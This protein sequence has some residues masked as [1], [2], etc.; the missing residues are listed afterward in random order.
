MQL[1]LL[2]Q[3]KAEHAWALL[4]DPENRLWTEQADY[5]EGALVLVELSPLRQIQ[6]IQDATCW[7]LDIVKHYLGTGMTPTLLEEE[8]QRAEQWRQ[9]LTLKNQE[10][11]RRVLEIEARRDQ[12]QELEENLKIEK[13][14]LEQ[15]AAQFRANLNGK[16]DEPPTES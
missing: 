1:R 15:M 8:V 4:D 14:K 16:H 7:V 9:S 10:L 13:E 11:N 2:A 6:Q 3:Q 5:N 12:I